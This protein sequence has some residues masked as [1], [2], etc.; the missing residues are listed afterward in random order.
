MSADVTITENATELAGLEAQ[1]DRYLNEGSTMAA[2][3]V[4]AQAADLA[5]SQGQMRD[6]P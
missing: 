1:A 2:V 6:S 5:L 3:L 4:L